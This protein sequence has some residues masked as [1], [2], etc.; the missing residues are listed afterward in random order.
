MF[1]KL[2]P[3]IVFLSLADSVE[4]LY[5]SIQISEDEIVLGRADVE[6]NKEVSKSHCRIHKD[7]SGQ[8]ILKNLRLGFS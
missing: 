4:R 2:Q 1:F 6:G 7:P 8:I 3:L 5:P